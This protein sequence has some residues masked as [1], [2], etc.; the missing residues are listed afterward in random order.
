MKKDRRSFDPRRHWQQTQGRLI[1]AGLVILLIVGGG[2]V[3]LLYGNMAAF[4]AV[5]CLLVAAGLV[6]LLWLILAL[7]EKWVKEDEP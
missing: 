3:W 5:A 6:G 1:V 2:L 7:L 4:S